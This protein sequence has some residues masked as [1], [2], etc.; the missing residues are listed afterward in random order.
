MKI[1]VVED[2]TPVAMMIVS[3]LTQAGCDVA[4]ANTGEKGLEMALEQKF[5]LIALN[6]DLP[7]A[8][9]FE[10]CGELKQRHFTRHTPV[11]FVS[12]RSSL[13]DQ[14]HGLDLGAAD[15]ITKP[16]E[17]TDFVFR[18]VSHAMTKTSPV[19]A[20]PTSETDNLQTMYKC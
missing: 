20:L 18:I 3:L 8:N 11:A 5:D 19:V 6:V 7:N 10:I 13:E 16:F 15:Y 2:D 9:G 14:Q 17:A 1:L 12:G 4:V